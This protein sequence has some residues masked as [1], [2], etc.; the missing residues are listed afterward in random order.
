MLAIIFDL[1]NSFL[2]FFVLF[3]KLDK[4]IVLNMLRA[5]F[6]QREKTRIKKVWINH[7]SYGTG[8]A[9]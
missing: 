9:L 7:G 3:N 6:Y 1:G 4:Y 2:L 5:D 8:E